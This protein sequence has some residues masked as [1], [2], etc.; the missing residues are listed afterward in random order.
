MPLSAAIGSRQVLPGKA[1]LQLQG[2][3]IGTTRKFPYGAVKVIKAFIAI[4]TSNFWKM[5]GRRR[6][7]TFFPLPYI[8]AAASKLNP[9]ATGRSPTGLAFEGGPFPCRLHGCKFCLKLR[10]PDVGIEGSYG[11]RSARFR[12]SLVLDVFVAL[13]QLAA[14][15]EQRL[16]S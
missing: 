1:T 14:Q 3:H 5:Q 11:G 2:Q 9:L 8:F 15:F 6:L 4:S 12:L 7:P 13:R 16:V 10:K